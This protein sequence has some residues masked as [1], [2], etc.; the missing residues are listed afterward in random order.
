MGFACL[1]MNFINV[2]SSQERQVLILFEAGYQC[3]KDNFACRANNYQAALYS[4]L[5]WQTKQVC[6]KFVAALHQKPSGKQLGQCQGM[7]Q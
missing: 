7:G 5:A 1:E 3:R 2:N 6:D 4:A